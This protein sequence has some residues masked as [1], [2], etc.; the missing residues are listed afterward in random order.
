MKN[1]ECE[2]CGESVEITYD[3]GYC[4]DC[5]IDNLPTGSDRQIKRDRRAK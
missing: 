3:G 4:E 5:A 1:T 2:K